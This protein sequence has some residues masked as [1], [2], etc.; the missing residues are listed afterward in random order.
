V[1]TTVL[2]N[3]SRATALLAAARQDLDGAEEALEAALSRHDRVTVPFDLG[4][5]LLSHG[6]VHRRR[7]RRRAARDAFR[8]ASSIFGELGARLWADRAVAE[9]ASLPIRRGASETLTPRERQ[10]AHLVAAG[11]SNPEVA[12]QLFMSRKTVEVNLTRIYRKLGLRSRVEL[13]TWLAR[14]DASK[15]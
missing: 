14:E 10:V 2:A 8:R 12:Q 5:T 7:G 1:R 15:T 3:A 13:A 4:R 6:Q 9:L 11:R